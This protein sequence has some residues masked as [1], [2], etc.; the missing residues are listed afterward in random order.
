MVADD[1]GDRPKVSAAVM[2]AAR[3]GLFQSA[4]ICSMGGA[5]SPDQSNDLTGQRSPGVLH[6]L[7]S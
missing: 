7:P 4:A 5:L 3:A 6:P 1:T 2:L